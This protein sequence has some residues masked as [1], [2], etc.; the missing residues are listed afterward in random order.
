MSA[1]AQ[2]DTEDTESTEDTEDTEDTESTKSAES[3]ES[4]EDMVGI[5]A[6]QL[7]DL[8][9]PR[10]AWNGSLRRSASRDAERLK[11]PFHAERGT[12]KGLN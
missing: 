8:L 7:R 9:V 12:S 10:S 11:L 2:Y 3:T 6:I 1:C 4:T 5:T